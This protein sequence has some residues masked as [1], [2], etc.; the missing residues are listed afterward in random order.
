M[1]YFQKDFIDFFKE[2]AANNNK[3]WF[4]ANRK[5]Y[6]TV[7][8][9]PFK[10]FVAKV[11][12]EV[13]KDD[14]TTSIEPKDAIFRINRD[15]RFSKDKTPYKLHVGAVISPKG[16]KD[17][18]NPGI[19]IELGPEHLGIFGGMWSPDKVQI[20]KI[21]KHIITNSSEFEKLISNS[22]FLK[23]FPEGIRGDKNKR[24]PKEYLD[25]AK[26]QELIFNKQFYYQAFINP[27]EIISEN[28]IDTIMKHYY[29][30]NPL[31]NFFKRAM[32]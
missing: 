21:R 18:G 3:E 10:V 32:Q 1:T 6:E 20:D 14:P 2:L 5:R 17:T 7:V 26:K 28:L 9:E 25:S 23:I 29:I 31:K 24:L 19:Y 11:I 4:D 27:E 13:H 22:D 12:D 8:R 30:A 16:R 15:I